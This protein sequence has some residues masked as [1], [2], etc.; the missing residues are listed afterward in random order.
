MATLTKD[1]VAMVEASGFDLVQPAREKL[2]AD[3]CAVLDKRNA[4]TTTNQVRAAVT[5]VLA[6]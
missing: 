3:V 4:G 6:K 1:Q 2:I 5:A